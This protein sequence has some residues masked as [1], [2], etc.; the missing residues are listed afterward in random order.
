MGFDFA[1]PATTR[2]RRAVS[3]GA[4]G[5]LRVRRAVPAQVRGVRLVCKLR[6]RDSVRGE[7]GSGAGAIAGCGARREEWFSQVRSF[8]SKIGRNTLLLLATTPEHVT[9]N[10]Y[11]PYTAGTAHDAPKDGSWILVALRQN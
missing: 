5:R 9:H 6:S 7:L 11:T 3:G 2:L 10:P 4:F 8:L 1:L